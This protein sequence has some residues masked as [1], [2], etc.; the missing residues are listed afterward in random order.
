MYILGINAYHGDSSACLIKDG[1]ILTAVE[2][3]RFNRI[4]HWSGFPEQSIKFCLHESNI[5]INDVDYITTNSNF[6]SNLHL[7]VYFAI[8]KVV[9]PDFLINQ[10]IRKRKK[11][12][13]K[14]TI[15]ESFSIK[16]LF[17]KIVNI[18]HHLSHISSSFFC[19]PFDESMSISIDGF[20]DFASLVIA[21]NIHN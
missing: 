4:K 15:K 18:D 10:I 9:N 13:L 11:T 3:E 7:K 17:P 6:Y 20:G 8:N 5:D 12:N 21:K 19:S 1:E 14:N 16:K 2:E